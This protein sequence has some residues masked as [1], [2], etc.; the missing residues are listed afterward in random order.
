[1]SLNLPEVTQDK[2]AWDLV[3]GCLVVKVVDHKDMA[4]NNS[5]SNQD[6][7]EVEMLL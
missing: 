3:E 2:V 7:P 1:M 5:N 4:N 6:M